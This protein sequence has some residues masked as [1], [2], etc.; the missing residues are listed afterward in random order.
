MGFEIPK[1]HIIRETQPRVQDFNAEEKRAKVLEGAGRRIE[2]LEAALQP[3][4]ITPP[5]SVPE[6]TASAEITPTQP[7]LSEEA[8]M[9]IADLETA[10]QRL[11]EAA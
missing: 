8:L 9:Q 3:A 11:R 7:E 4:E 5:I 2:D 10:Y 1:F 6:E